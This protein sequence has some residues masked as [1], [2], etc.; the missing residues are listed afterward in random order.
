MSRNQWLVTLVLSV[1]AASVLG[2]L[3][4]FVLLH[5]TEGFGTYPPGPA[6]TTDARTPLP[7]ETPTSTVAA[8]ATPMPPMATQEPAPSLDDRAYLDCVEAIAR[9]AIGWGED[10]G[11][12]LS[13]GEGDPSALCEAVAQFDL[14]AR[15]IDLRMRHQDCTVPFTPRL[16][17]AH[18]YMADALAEHSTGMNF[19]DR[20]CSQDNL[21][22]FRLLDEANRHLDLGLTYLQQFNSEV[23]L[24]NP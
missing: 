21:W 5:L 9:M 8:T 2:C 18:M 6:E 7:S 16:R 11:V 12:A 10:F 14:E 23:E 20:Y 22:D 19:M 17:R 4:A 3:G 15:A 1:A 13:L 24:Y